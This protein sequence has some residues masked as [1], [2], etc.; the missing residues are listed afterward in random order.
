MGEGQFTHKLRHV[1]PGSRVRVQGPWGT[2]MIPLKAYSTL[3]LCTGGVGITPALAIL[4][5]AIFGDTSSQ[6]SNSRHNQ[7][8]IFVW[9][10]R[11]RAGIS[12]FEPELLELK[13]AAEK[14]E[15]DIEWH[16]HNTHI[17]AKNDEGHGVDVESG[18]GLLFAAGRPDWRGILSKPLSGGTGVFVCGPGPLV[19]EVDRV[20][21]ELGL[22]VHKEAFEL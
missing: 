2:P 8:I 5:D 4:D 11:G 7:K 9:C 21:Y 12:S 10:T 17:A 3:I 20:S 18:A 14:R 22:P 13:L 19:T 16:L 15:K 1:S 6:Q